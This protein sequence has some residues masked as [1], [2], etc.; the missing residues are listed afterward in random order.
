MPIIALTH[1]TNIVFIRDSKMDYYSQKKTRKD[2]NGFYLKDIIPVIPR[3]ALT[4][5][6]LNKSSYAI[7]LRTNK[8]LSI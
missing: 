8:C 2:W 3:L 7:E 4:H 1:K 5:I 6:S